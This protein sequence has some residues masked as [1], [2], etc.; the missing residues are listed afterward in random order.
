MSRLKYLENLDLKSVPNDVLKAIA[1]AEDVNVGFQIAPMIDVVFVIMLFFMVM[2]GAVKT[3][4]L[5]ITALPGP[6]GEFHSG[7]PEEILISVSDDGAISLNDEELVAAGQ[8]DFRRLKMTLAA[9]SSN[10]ARHNEKVLVT[11][12]SDDAARY[13]CIIDVMNALTAARL[14]NVTFTVGHDEP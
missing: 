8:T 11:V 9:L 14:G 10:A 3:E 2:A 1:R 7:V 5:M 12:E 6:Q 4:R 13:Q